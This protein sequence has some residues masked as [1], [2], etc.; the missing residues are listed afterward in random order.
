MGSIHDADVSFGDADLPALLI[1]LHLVDCGS[2]LQD[3]FH[4]SH[5]EQGGQNRRKRELTPVIMGADQ[6]DRSS[7]YEPD[8]GTRGLTTAIS[9]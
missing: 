5:T 4:S 6:D 9:R 2:N 3:F 7:P 1:G 8:K